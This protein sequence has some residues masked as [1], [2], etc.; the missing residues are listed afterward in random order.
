SDEKLCE[1]KKAQA[2]RSG[3]RMAANRRRSTTGVPSS[4]CSTSAFRAALSAVRSSTRSIPQ[5]L[6]GRSAPMF[7]RKPGRPVSRRTI[8]D[9]SCFLEAVAD[10][11]ERLDHL[12]VVVDHLELLAQPL[13]VAVDGAVVDIDLV[14][15]GGVHQGVAA[16]HHAG[17]GGERL[18]DQELGDGK[19]DRLVLPGAGMALGVHAQQAALQHL[20]AVDFLD[21]RAILAAGAA[22]HRLD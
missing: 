21:W 11:I 2:E 6:S 17:A 16:L 1:T 7:Y 18:Q 19:G 10:A 22:Q 13:D 12:E 15:V 4:A 9:A 8:K 14:V 3:R 20:G 5:G